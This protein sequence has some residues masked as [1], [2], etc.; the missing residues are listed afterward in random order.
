[1]VEEDDVVRFLKDK[2]GQTS[3]NE[4]AQELAVPKYGPNS[5]YALLQTLKNKGIWG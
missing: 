1:M 3:L 5:A 2:Q 4:I